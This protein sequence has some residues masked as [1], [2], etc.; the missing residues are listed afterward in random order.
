MQD[1]AVVVVGLLTRPPDIKNIFP[2]WEHI[3]K[4]VEISYRAQLDEI[5]EIPDFRILAMIRKLG[6]H[7]WQL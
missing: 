6:A 1:S 5:R 3:K 7:N 2:A 4:G